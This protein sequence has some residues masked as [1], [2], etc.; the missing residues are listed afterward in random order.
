[1]NNMPVQLWVI[2]IVLVF[3]LAMMV[4]GTE[5]TI[6]MFVRANFDDTCNGYLAQI[7]RDG[8]LGTEAREKLTAELNNLGITNVSIEAPEHGEWGDNV[9]LKVTGEYVFQTTDYKNLSKDT[10]TKPITYENNT[11]NLCLN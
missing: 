10:K 8:G 11:R 2:A 9:T 7:E 3:C 5:Y 4:T 6:P 1:M